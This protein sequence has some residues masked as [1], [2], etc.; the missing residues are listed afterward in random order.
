M[1]IFVFA[2]TATG[3]S[4]VAK[5]YKNVIDM[6]STL[7]KYIGN[8]LEDES[9]KST[10]RFLNEEWPENYFKALKEV[11]DKY[12]YILV[13]DE[14]CNDFILNNGYEYWYVYPRR[15]LKEDVQQF[16]CRDLNNNNNGNNNIKEIKINSPLSFFLV[17]DG[18]IDGGMVL[19]S[20][21]ELFIEWQNKFIETIISNNK[22]NGIL[23]SS[24]SQLSMEIKVQL[25]VLMIIFMIY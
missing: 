15:E 16:L 24:C 10:S 20:I 8:D 11:K 21:Y 9:L 17:D 14:I 12:D 2:F 25:F 7:Y 1:G 19:S 3:K 5:K 6:E 23:N 22:F 13:A 4:N 18:D